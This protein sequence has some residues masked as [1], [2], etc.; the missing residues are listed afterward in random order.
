MKNRIVYMCPEGVIFGFDK[1]F[2]DDI[3]KKILN[4][5][6]LISPREQAF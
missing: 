5:S 4:A 2:A 1:D 6:S 3:D